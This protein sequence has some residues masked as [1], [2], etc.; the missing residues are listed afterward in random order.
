MF[1]EKIKMKLSANDIPINSKGIQNL[2][3]C[4][5]T[6]KWKKKWKRMGGGSIAG[7]VYCYIRGN[8]FLILFKL[9]GIRS[10]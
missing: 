3:L 7:W 1:D 10:L 8:L 9:K 4:V 2:V 5:L 6:E